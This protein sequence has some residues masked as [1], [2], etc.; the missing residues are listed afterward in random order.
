VAAGVVLPQALLQRVEHRL[1]LQA[2]HHAHVSNHTT[3]M[4]AKA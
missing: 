3:P 2:Q 4:S 1:Q